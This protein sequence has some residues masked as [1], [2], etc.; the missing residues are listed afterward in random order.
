MKQSKALNCEQVENIIQSIIEGVKQAD[1][2]EKFKMQG[3]ILHQKMIYNILNHITYH[4]CSSY[5]E[6]EKAKVASKNNRR[7]PDKKQRTRRKK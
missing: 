6:K 2:I 3:I 5:E 1:I 4:E 7:G